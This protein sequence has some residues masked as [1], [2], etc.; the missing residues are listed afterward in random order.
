MGVGVGTDVGV[1]DIVGAACDD[2][3]WVVVATKALEGNVW[4]E[5][6]EEFAKEVD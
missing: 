3:R 5:E 4:A 1:E 6:P 2:P